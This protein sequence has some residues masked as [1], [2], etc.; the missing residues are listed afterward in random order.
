VV[1]ILLEFDSLKRKFLDNIKNVKVDFSNELYNYLIQYIAE[2]N[3]KFKSDNL[4]I[5]DRYKN[6]EILKCAAFINYRKDYGEDVLS[7][8]VASARD[9]FDSLATSTLYSRC[10]PSIG[11]AYNNQKLYNYFYY[12]D[13]GIRF[14]FNNFDWDIV[15]GVSKLN[16]AHFIYETFIKV[17]PYLY[18]KLAHMVYDKLEISPKKSNG[19]PIS[20]SFISPT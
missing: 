14:M 10:S 3:L 11:S 13:F 6:F 15:R 20:T 7:Q 12:K 8:R 5:G 17:I 4:L 16:I 19:L 18:N 1:L 2:R 9:R